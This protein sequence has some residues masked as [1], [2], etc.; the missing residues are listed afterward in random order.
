VILSA[1]EPWFNEVLPWAVIER[2]GALALL[3]MFGWWF[4]AIANRWMGTMHETQRR[5]GEQVVAIAGEVR[6]LILVMGKAV[7]E[8]REDRRRTYEAV[9]GISDRVRDVVRD[10]LRTKG[11][12]MT[13]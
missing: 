11:R 6:Q 5:H 8:A 12:E 10:E 7:E 9:L 4:L 1:T 3:G 13:Q 2:I